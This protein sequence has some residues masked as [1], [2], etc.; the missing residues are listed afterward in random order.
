MSQVGLKER[1]AKDKTESK[2]LN[3][4]KSFIAQTQ[5]KVDAKLSQSRL[6]PT[7][8][9][10]KGE[11]D[12]FHPSLDL[13]PSRKEDTS[14]NVISDDEQPE[15]VAKEIFPPDETT[16]HTAKGKGARE[17]QHQVQAPAPP[18]NSEKMQDSVPEGTHEN[19][20]GNHPCDAEELKQQEESREDPCG[21]SAMNN[22]AV[23]N[24][25][26][27]RTDEAEPDNSLLTPPEEQSTPSAIPSPEGTHEKAE[28][29]EEPTPDEAD[30]N[31]VKPF[32][33]PSLAPDGVFAKFMVKHKGE[34]TF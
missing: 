3:S 26:A 17:P 16:A 30:G 5:A 6:L 18:T 21:D 24:D 23:L 8:S 12:P 31:S 9:P 15:D 29:G 20:E 2:Q 22:T 32:F 34:I 33:N 11:N 27:G 14:Y 19:T 1:S 10:A 13:S 4:V 7:L 25:N 28:D